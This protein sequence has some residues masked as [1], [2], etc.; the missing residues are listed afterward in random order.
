MKLIIHLVNHKTGESLNVLVASMSD[1]LDYIID[2]PK[3]EIG[4][5]VYYVV[6][7]K[8]YPSF[9]LPRS[10]AWALAEMERT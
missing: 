6:D 2:H 1:A 5:D 7:G 4:V 9:A 8:E 3:I 10:V